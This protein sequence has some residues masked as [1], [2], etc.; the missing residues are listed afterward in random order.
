M[1]SIRQLL[2]FNLNAHTSCAAE[3]PMAGAECEHTVSQPNLNVP[4]SAAQQQLPCS[5]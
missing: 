4:E 1:H 3:L 5:S 2:E